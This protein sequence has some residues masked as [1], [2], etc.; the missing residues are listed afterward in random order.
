MWGLSN[1]LTISNILMKTLIV[2][3]IARGGNQIEISF[4]RQR[5]Q[6]EAIDG[7]IRTHCSRFSSNDDYI[8]CC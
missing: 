6:T 3:C 1:I 5:Y 7:E 4:K 2:D 8:K